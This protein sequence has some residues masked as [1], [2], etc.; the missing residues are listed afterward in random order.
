MVPELIK[1]AIILATVDMPP[2]DDNAPI[3]RARVVTEWFD[4]LENDV[5]YMPW[6][7]Q[8]PDLNPIEHL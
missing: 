7:S 4:E 2:Y 8:S 1:K 3:H 6:L 5:N